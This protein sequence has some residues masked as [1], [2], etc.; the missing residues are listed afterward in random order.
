MRGV[1]SAA[2]RGRAVALVAGLVL[3][4]CVFGSEGGGAGTMNFLLTTSDVSDP[5]CRTPVEI[6]WLVGALERE[7]GPGFVLAV[8]P[9]K[10]ES[11]ATISPPACVYSAEVQRT[12]SVEKN[13]VVAR[14]MDEQEWV[15]TCDEFEAVISDEGQFNVVRFVRGQQ[16]CTVD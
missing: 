2:K 1:L 11:V 6:S 9:D 15:D 10:V 8:L 13:F 16:A 4:A 14:S 12:T 3:S 5:N 7:V